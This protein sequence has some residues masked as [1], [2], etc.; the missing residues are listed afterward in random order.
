MIGLSDLWYQYRAVNNQLRWKEKGLEIYMIW[1]NHTAG[2]NSATECFTFW[3]HNSNKISIVECNKSHDFDLS[4]L[5]WPPGAPR[6]DWFHARPPCIPLLVVLPGVTADRLCSE[7]KYYTWTLTFGQTH[8]WINSMI[9][10]PRG[11]ITRHILYIITARYL[12]MNDD[13]TQCQLDK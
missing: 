3:F 8:L 6:M 12:W 4:S 10:L 9:M 7:S 2:S 1:E 5:L 13:R 11:S